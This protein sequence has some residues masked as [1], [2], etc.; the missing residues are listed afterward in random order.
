VKLI[1]HRGWAQGSGENTLAA[2]ARAA[3]D[4]RLSGVEFDVR[5]DPNSEA[6]VVMHDPPRSGAPALALDPA[7]AFLSST[8]LELFVELKQAGIVEDVIRQ[9]IKGGIAERSV[10]FAFPPVAQSFPWTKARPVRLGV[11]LLYPWTMQHFIRRHSPDLVLVGWDRRPWTRNAFRGWW[12]AFSLDRLQRRI[13]K[14][15][16]A[17]IVRHSS[18]LTWLSRCNVAGAIADMDAIADWSGPST[19][20]A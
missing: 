10:I 12:S 20:P 15:V 14:P 16:V 19:G 2:F 5:R 3:A 1:A 8:R 17:G 13:G 7:T 18:D 11:I 9:L 6:L 4:P